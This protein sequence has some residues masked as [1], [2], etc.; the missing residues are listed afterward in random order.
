MK[1]IIIYWSVLVCCFTFSCS[2]PDPICGCIKAGNT[3]NKKAHSIL[4]NGST[5][6]DEKELQ[7]LKKETKKACAEFET[8]GG[9]EMKKRM[10]E[11]D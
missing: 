4:E 11:C 8:M 9:Q 5:E 2:S 6:K 7:Q 1:L 10:A 3:L